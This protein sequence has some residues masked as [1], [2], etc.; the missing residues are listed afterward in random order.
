MISI[1]RKDVTMYVVGN[2]VEI[3]RQPVLTVIENKGMVVDNSKLPTSCR[4]CE[5]K[6]EQLWTQS[7]F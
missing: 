4:Y 3:I 1:K 6:D 7:Y 5:L 2:E